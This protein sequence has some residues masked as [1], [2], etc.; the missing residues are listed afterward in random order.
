MSHQL[1]MLLLLFLIIVG[2]FFAG[3]TLGAEDVVHRNGYYSHDGY[4]CV[5][6]IDRSMDEIM[7]TTMHELVHVMSEEERAHFNLENDSCKN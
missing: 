6:T 1:R 5:E 4:F 3:Y 2:T 7:R